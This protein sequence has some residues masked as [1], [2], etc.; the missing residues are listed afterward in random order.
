MRRGDPHLPR[1]ATV[2]LSGAA[3]NGGPGHGLV[4]CAEIRRSAASQHSGMIGRP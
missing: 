3:V 4:G 1:A 2:R